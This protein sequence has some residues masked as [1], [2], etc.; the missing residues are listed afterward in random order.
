MLRVTVVGENGVE[1][2]EQRIAEGRT[3]AR[4]G[5]FEW[6]LPAGIVRWSDELCRIY[7]VEPGRFEGTVAGYFARV[8]PDDRDRTSR[9]VSAVFEK[10]RGITYEHRIVRPDGSIRILYSR[11]DLISDRAGQPL[12]MIG[13]CWDVTDRRAPDATPESTVGLLRAVLEASVDGI[14]VV[15][16]LGEVVTFNERF[17]A[18]WAIPRD[19]ALEGSD[20]VLLDFVLPQLADPTTFLERVHALYADPE[21]DSFE[22]VRFKDGRVLERHSRPHRIGAVI[23]G[24]V[25]TFRD[26]TQR[27]NLLARQTLLADAARLLSSL[28]VETALAGLIRIALPYL[29][30]SCAIDLLSDDGSQRL[31]SG[32]VAGAEPL[33]ASASRLENLVA[34]FHYH[35][36]RNVMIVPL[37]QE[38]KEAGK[39]RMVGTIAFAAQQHRRYTPADLAVAEELAHRIELELENRRLVSALRDALRSRDDFLS[40]AAHEIRGPLTSIRLAVDRLRAADVSASQS[41]QLLALLAREDRRLAR[42]VEELVDLSRIRGVGLELDVEENV[43]LPQIIRDVVQRL[44]PELVRAGS[45]VILDL[46]DEPVRGRW[47]RY[48]MDQVVT[49]LLVNALKFGL[50]KPIEISVRAV[51]GTVTLAVSDRGIGVVPELRERIFEPFERGVSVRHYGGLGLG[52][53]IVRMI[54]TRLGG[55]VRVEPI[56]GGGSRFV[57]Q[58]PQA[59]NH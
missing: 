44:E 34:S 26:V 3:A 51:A 59:R 8:H 12:H 24:R 21:A 11:V 6:D 40:I 49:N 27:E 58:L 13:S 57:V 22:V 5:S 17:L 16:R 47:D 39:T 1:A 15:D 29:G 52:L 53:Y 35:E 42:F 38:D 43:D 31:A 45:T 50:G 55:T 18:L 37:R 30:E 23:V 14:L 4:A 56:D 9:I 10:P 7:G 25:W 48:R 41:E 36:G 28:D 46:P 19:L 32:A 2:F 54:V 33:P 20:Q